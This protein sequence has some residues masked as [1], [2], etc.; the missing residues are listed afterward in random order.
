MK[1][2]IIVLFIL[3]IATAAGA[4][5]LLSSRVELLQDSTVKILMVLCTAT[6]ILIGKIFDSLKHK[7]QKEQTDEMSKEVDEIGKG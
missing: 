7:D 4:T 6:G 2:Y 3:L 1:T 5:I